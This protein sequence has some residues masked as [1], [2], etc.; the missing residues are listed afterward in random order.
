MNIDPLE[1]AFVSGCP[2]FLSIPAKKILKLK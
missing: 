2:V 1:S